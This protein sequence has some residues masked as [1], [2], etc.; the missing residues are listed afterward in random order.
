VDT[1][2]QRSPVGAPRPFESR[3]VVLDQV[4]SSLTHAADEHLVD[5]LQP[6]GGSLEISTER[7]CGRVW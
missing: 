5:G 3:W 4:S 1:A 2:W 6:T 7:R